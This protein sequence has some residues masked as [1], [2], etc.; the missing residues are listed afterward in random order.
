MT[1][2]YITAMGGDVTES[3]TGYKLVWPDGT[4]MDNIQFV[5]GQAMAKVLDLKDPRILY[6][7]NRVLP[8]VSGMSIPQIKVGDLSRK[9]SG[10]WSL[11]QI[12]VSNQRTRIRKILPLF[13]HDDGRIRASTAFQLWDHLLKESTEI[14]FT[15][16]LSETT[17]PPEIY[18]QM[19]KIAEKQ[20]ENQLIKA[21]EVYE[22]Y[23]RK[24]R[25]KN[26][27]YYDLRIRAASRIPDD[28]TRILRIDELEKERKEWREELERNGKPTLDL[29]A[30]IITHVRGE[31]D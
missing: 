18:K 17:T 8:Q 22:N 5:K 6:I 4:A 11:W 16:S 26:K 19:K 27:S 15:G 23:L 14:E 28:K 24:S 31:N 30:L 21:K 2:S 10:Y 1:L 3:P 29:H 20:G 9:V 25:E 7:M 13:V 12:T